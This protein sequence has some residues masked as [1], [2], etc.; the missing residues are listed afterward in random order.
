MVV[1]VVMLNLNQCESQLSFLWDNERIFCPL[2]ITLYCTELTVIEDSV[3]LR[4]SDLALL[5]LAKVELDTSGTE[6]SFPA[7]SD[8]SYREK[9]LRIIPF[10]QCGV[11]LSNSHYIVNTHFQLRFN[12]KNSIHAC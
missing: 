12:E 2:V 7:S 1:W 5:K 4:S 6:R 3:T 11:N 10:Y 9:V 8:I